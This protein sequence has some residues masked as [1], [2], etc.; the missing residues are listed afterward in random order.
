M[1]RIHVGEVYLYGDKEL[2][3]VSRVII[4]PDFIHAGLG[5][6]VALLQLAESVQSF[7]NV[8]PVK[9][10]SESLEVT[11]KDVCWVTGWGA[12]SMHSKFWGRTGA[13]AA[14][15]L[16]EDS[17]WAAPRAW[18]QEPESMESGWHA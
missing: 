12:V 14:N 13:V 5:S 2:L 1:F 9:L 6:D 10:S 17:W 3:K 4:H 15:L 7:P 18:G 16:P 8:K 11:K